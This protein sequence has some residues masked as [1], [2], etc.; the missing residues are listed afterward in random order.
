MNNKSNLSFV[1]SITRIIL[2]KS[3]AFQML[4]GPS[5]LREKRLKDTLSLRSDIGDAWQELFKK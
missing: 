1:D 2:T 5:R 3:E 4:K